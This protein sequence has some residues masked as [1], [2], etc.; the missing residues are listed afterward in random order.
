MRNLNIVVIVICIILMVIL[1]YI[2]YDLNEFKNNTPNYG[3]A[4][5]GLGVVVIFG[6]TL[7][8]NS[9]ICGILFLITIIIAIKKKRILNLFTLLTIGIIIFTYNF[10]YIIVQ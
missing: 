10:P 5:S 3:S 8:V 1:L 6:T 9:I 7:I 2:D 4:N